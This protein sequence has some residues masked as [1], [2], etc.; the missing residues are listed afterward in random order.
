MS[1]IIN[2]SLT[3]PNVS[4]ET[5]NIFH[6]YYLELKRWNETISLMKDLESYDI[7]FERHLEDA[8]DIASHIDG[9]LIDIGSGAGIPGIPL[10]ILGKK[11]KLIES[12]QKKASFLNYCIKK[13]KL[14]AECI[15]IRIENLNESSDI[16]T[17]SAR[18]LAPLVALLKYQ[19]C[20]SRETIGVFLKGEKIFEEIEEAKKE[21]LFDY[22]I[23]DR[24]N[25][26]GYII[27]VKN[28]EK[29][30]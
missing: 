29:K 21:W 11:V 7:F 20:V 27:I 2:K 17:I 4:R 24:I 26:R 12:N 30:E 19:L 10:A 6:A 5:Q 23:Y 25:K 18:A 15:N 1:E 8:I 16:S 14:N 3:P 13:F 22:E 9:N 28:V